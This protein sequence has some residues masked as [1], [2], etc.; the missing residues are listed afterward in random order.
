MATRFVLPLAALPWRLFPPSHHLNQKNNRF[1]QRELFVVGS[2]CRHQLR[3]AVST[4]S[5]VG[6]ARNQ[7]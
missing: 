1:N 7:L 2:L 3:V 6:D 4:K 5:A